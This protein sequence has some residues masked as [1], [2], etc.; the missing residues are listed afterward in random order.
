MNPFPV[1]QLRK[2]RGIVRS[3]VYHIVAKHCV[4]HC[5]LIIVCGIVLGRSKPRLCNLKMIWILA[6]TLKIGKN[7][8][9]FRFDR[10]LEFW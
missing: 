1:R 2:F 5:A 10:N 4:R 6:N 9:I 8:E 7:S 3:T